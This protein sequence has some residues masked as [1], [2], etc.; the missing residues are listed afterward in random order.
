[1]VWYVGRRAEL[2]LVHH[3]ET[4][5]RRSGHYDADERLV[6]TAFH[7][8]LQQRIADLDVEAARSKVTRFLPDPTS[9]ELWSRAF[10]NH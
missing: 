9:V 7:T 3:L 4:R 10:F 2:D 6:E 8:M 5:M 1:M